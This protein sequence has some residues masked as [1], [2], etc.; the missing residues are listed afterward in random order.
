MIWF[1]CGNPSSVQN[2]SNLEIPKKGVNP[3]PHIPGTSYRLQETL[4]S[5]QKGKSG[6]TINWEAIDPILRQAQ[7]Q[8]GHTWVAV[9]GVID[10]TGALYDYDVQ[11]LSFSRKAVEDVGGKTRPFIYEIIKEGETNNTTIRVA[12]ALIPDSDVA[13][14]ELTD[15]LRPKVDEEATKKAKMPDGYTCYYS[16]EVIGNTVYFTP[17]YCEMDAIEVQ[18]GGDDD[19]GSGGEDYTDDWNWPDWDEGGGGGS[20]SG[21]SSCDT[22]AIFPP[23]GCEEEDIESLKLDEDLYLLKDPDCTKPYSDQDPSI[24]LKDYAIWCNSKQFTAT[25]LTI[26]TDA[27]QRIK[28][29]N[30]V[31]SSIAGFGTSLLINDRLREFP[32]S[33]YSQSGGLGGEFAN[34]GGAFAVISEVYLDSYSNSSFNVTGMNNL[35]NGYS[36]D[37]NLEWALVHEL[38]HAMGE[39]GH[40]EGDP[41]LTPNVQLC[42]GNN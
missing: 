23:E 34:G 26:I 18:G 38:E 27:L 4:N 42:T 24:R 15:W 1:G 11:P 6:S 10:S 32:A 14:K 12:V 39:Q 9:F 7:Q 30:S 3:I 13:Q 17:V 41:W 25:R 8:T 19:W 16:M 37:V 29:R 20:G 33:A 35:G 21:D 22:S 5:D 31:C 28:S 2:E 36:H 40:S